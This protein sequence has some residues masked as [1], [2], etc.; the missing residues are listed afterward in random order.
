MRLVT[1]D[2]GNTNPHVGFFT[3]GVLQSVV[4]LDQYSPTLGD[5]VLIASVGPKL[6]IQPSFDLKSK[7][8][9]T[10]FFDMKVH[11]AETLGEDRLIAS[12]GIFKK[13]KK[14]ERVL[15]IDA[16]TFLKTD[17]ITEDGFQGGYIFPGISRFLKI[18]TESAQLPTL[19]KDLLFKGNAD[20][21]HTT[22][23]AILKATELYLKACV[24]EVITKIAPDKI[25]FTGG[26]MN[27]IKKLI[28]SKVHVETDRHLIHS[29]L[30]LI[31][32]LHLRQE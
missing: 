25:V 26:D 21:P 10:H 29:A 8:T 27:E 13:L 32:D 9:P 23:E 28:S 31:H 18:Y 19:S 15:L 5:F 2:N 14:N 17:L 12:Y 22:N 24:E 30:S 6:S 4:P 1:I 16:G 20:L 3:E 7:R 11:Y